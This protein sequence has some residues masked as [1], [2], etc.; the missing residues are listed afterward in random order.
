MWTLINGESKTEY[1]TEEAYLQALSS[2][3]SVWNKESHIAEIN[4]L[5]D[6]IVSDLIKS[7][8]YTDMAE[9]MLWEAQPESEYHAEANSIVEWYRSTCLEIESYS[10]VVDEI[11][12]LSVQDFINSLT[13]YNG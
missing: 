11:T 2:L 4:A 10:N 1:S 3:P 9:L 6:V 5:H 12:A 7:F 13:K 8:N